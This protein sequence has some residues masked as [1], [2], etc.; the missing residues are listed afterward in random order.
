MKEKADLQSNV[1]AILDVLRAMMAKFFHDKVE[2]KIGLVKDF[3]QKLVHT[4]H[5]ADR[6]LEYDQTNLILV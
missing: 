5:E 3:P 4:I 1:C 2:K 6:Y